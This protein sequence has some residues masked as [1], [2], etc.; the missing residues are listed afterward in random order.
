MLW[1]QKEDKSLDG[2]AICMRDGRLYTYSSQAFLSCRSAKDGNEVWRSTQADLLAAI[3][4][5]NNTA[6]FGTAFTVFLPVADQPE[7]VEARRAPSFNYAQRTGRNR[8]LDELV[9][10]G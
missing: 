5:D 6:T 1:S 9:A 10:V 4:K 8:L 7:E 2:R 3:G